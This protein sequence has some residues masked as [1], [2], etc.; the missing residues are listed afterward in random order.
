IKILSSG[1]CNPSSAAFSAFDF[2]NTGSVFAAFSSYF[3]FF[4]SM[5]KP[6]PIP[7]FIEFGL[8]KPPKAVPEM[9]PVKSDWVDFFLA[10][11]ELRPN[12]KKAYL[13]QLRQFQCWLEFKHWADVDESDLS[14][15]KTYLKEKPTRG[16]KFGL[17]AASINQA[18]AT[19]QSFFK[20]LATRRFIGFNPALTLEMVTLAPPQPKDLTVE[21]VQQLA[22][23]L[24]YR[25]QLSV[26]DTGH[27]WTA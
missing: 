2:L 13:R 18:L 21:T 27:P 23:G 5:A 3:F 9:A 20:W 16:G 10:D 25:G 19:I 14:R 12:T 26:R 1:E 7:K 11:R 15:Y 6:D 8:D 17:S 4:F 22:D 24:S